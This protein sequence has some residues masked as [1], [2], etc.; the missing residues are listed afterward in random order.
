MTNLVA[1]SPAPRT[2]PGMA[3]VPEG[4]RARR[5]Q[6]RSEA[7]ADLIRD[8]FASPE[9]AESISKTESFVFVFTQLEG[10]TSS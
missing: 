4:W 3:E 10:E 1:L 7:L 2:V 9:A 8:A 5:A 6:F